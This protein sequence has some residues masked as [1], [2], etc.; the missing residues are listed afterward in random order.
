MVKTRKYKTRLEFKQAIDD[1]FKSKQP[2]TICGLALAL[3][4]TRQTLCQYNK[5]TQE[6][7]E[8]CSDLVKE[9]KQRCEAF[10]EAQL[11]RGKGTAHGVMFNL[12]ANFGW[13]EP[14][15]IDHTHEHR[16]PKITK[17]EAQNLQEA[18]NKEF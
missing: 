1:F 2:K 18:F 16:F 13:R 15:Q 14:Q 5:N 10:W 7:G 17:E 4:M 9:A 12:K 11:L 3:G 6:S 8:D